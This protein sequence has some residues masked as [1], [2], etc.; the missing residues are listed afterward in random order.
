MLGMRGDRRSAAARCHLAV[1]YKYVVLGTSFSVRRAILGPGGGPT[2]LT[3]TPDRFLLIV[4]RSNEEL[5]NY[6]QQHFTGDDTV[7]VVVERRQ[8]DRRQGPR[9]P[10][11]PPAD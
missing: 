7:R 2:S 9:E 4:S 10:S 6:L 11:P 3:I 1:I 8:G 5:A